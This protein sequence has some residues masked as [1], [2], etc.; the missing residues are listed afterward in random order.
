MRLVTVL[1]AAAALGAIA[2]TA[3]ARD[4]CG[5]G[6]FYN[7]YR[8]APEGYTRGPDVRFFYGQPEYRVDYRRRRGACANPDF[9]VQD[10]VC[11]PYRG[12]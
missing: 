11:K 3:E 1:L 8:C 5:R 6:M 7:G 12:Y 2:T 4:G 9:T 10:G